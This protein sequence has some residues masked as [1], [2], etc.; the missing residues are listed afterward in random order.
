MDDSMQVGSGAAGEP[1]VPLV[2]DGD[3]A[4]DGAL[5]PAKKWRRSKVIW[6]VLGGLLIVAGAAVAIG[7][8]KKPL[9][10]DEALRRAAAFMADATTYS[11]EVSSTSEYSSGEAG[12]PGSTTVDRSEAT[13]AVALPDRWLHHEN[14]GYSVS[15]SIRFDDT[16]YYRSVARDGDDELEDELWIEESLE[17]EP[18]S[19]RSESV[20]ADETFFTLAAGG[21]T[22]VEPT[23]LA[24][25]LDRLKDATVIERPPGRVVVGAEVKL[26]ASQLTEIPEEADLS[27]DEIAEIEAS[28]PKKTTIEFEA[29]T[30][31]IPVRLALLTEASD[32]KSDIEITFTA[33]NQP[34]EIERPGSES[35]EPTPWLD[36]DAL[37]E[38]RPD[39]TLVAP[40]TPPSG[41]EMVAVEG[42]VDEYTDSLSCPTIS[43]G[44][45]TPRDG[46]DGERMALGDGE[47]DYF[48]LHFL[49][50][51]CAEEFD[52]DTPFEA[53]PF[54]AVPARE[55]EGWE[56]LFGETVVQVDTTLDDDALVAV[57]ASLAPV[58]LDAALA[59]VTDLM[60]HNWETYGWG[61]VSG[62]YS[63]TS[64]IDRGYYD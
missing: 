16:G 34:V 19:E 5:P 60:K 61:G 59:S 42:R 33:W 6:L 45:A 32:S 35:I 39:L 8:S 58:D 3:S 30:K 37:A 11:Y 40:T 2:P 57:I 23:A 22:S 20:L 28:T 17:L 31:G 51:A 44:Y 48:D 46:D 14:D 27:E 49:P 24:D 26:P 21:L 12:G 29:T 7:A 41:M 52:A 53:G 62:G 25:V 4:V 1:L 36:E 43:I 18:G 13:G 10:A 38:A 55:V 54:G 64:Q 15:E 47:S 56:L 63:Y 9:S 50:R